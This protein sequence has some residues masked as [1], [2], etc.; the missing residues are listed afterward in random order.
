V[1]RGVTGPQQPVCLSLRGCA[2]NAAVASKTRWMVTAYC[3]Q[4]DE[5]IACPDQVVEASHSAPA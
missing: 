4:I 1:V 3:D 2:L 5:A